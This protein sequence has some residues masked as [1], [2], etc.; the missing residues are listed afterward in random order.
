MPSFDRPVKKLESSLLILKIKLFILLAL[1]LQSL[2]S[3]LV[4]SAQQQVTV[5]TLIHRKH[6][7]W[8]LR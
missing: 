3:L 8:V 2:M 5:W 7:N 4:L 6:L 1:H